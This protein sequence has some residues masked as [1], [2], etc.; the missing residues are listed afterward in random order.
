VIILTI[1]PGKIF[2]LTQ[3]PGIP[4]EKLNLPGKKQS[5]STRLQIVLE[6]DRDVLYSL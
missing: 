1:D 4:S 6:I 3:I 2:A 5:K